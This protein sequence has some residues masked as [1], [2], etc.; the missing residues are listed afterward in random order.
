MDETDDIDVRDMVRSA[1]RETTS[2]FRETMR[3]SLNAALRGEQLVSLSAPASAPQRAR[4]LAVA[5][6]VLVVGVVAAVLAFADDD[7][8]TVTPVTVPPES[9][10]PTTAATSTEVSS[11]EVATTALPT[12]AVPTSLAVADPT[13]PLPDPDIPLLSV[14]A[15]FDTSTTNPPLATVR[16]AGDPL[17]GHSAFFQGDG[18]TVWEQDTDDGPL[19][20]T[21][22]TLDGRQAW[23]VDVPSLLGARHQVGTIELGP[24]DVLYAYY[25]GTEGSQVI[26][27]P[28]SGHRAGQT[29]ATWLVPNTCYETYCGPPMSADG[30][31]VSDTA[32]TP[33]VDGAG[34]P[35]GG[36]FQWPERAST[37]DD[38]GPAMPSAWPKGDEYGNS[39]IS[40]R[41]TVTLG[42][43]S[44]VFDAVGV[45]MAGD[46]NYLRQQVPGDG[47]VLVWFDTFDGVPGQETTSTKFLGI[48]SPDGAMA[49]VQL[50]ANVTDVHGS[51]GR[52][53][54]TTYDEPTGTYTLA[55]LVTG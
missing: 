17:F 52:I 51:D 36:T 24:F 32:T 41:T 15:R 28:T 7:R 30:L 33:Y 55:E 3:G 13:A 50:P 54:V 40:N 21:H 6:A 43:T 11:T 5:A 9:T 26:A 14:D 45:L 34:S 27:V 44:W 10:A 53:Y 49:F 25:E 2:E 29:V 19:R 12:T 31:I 46:Y 39:L 1:G 8:D 4:W 42:G 47:S 35:V 37:M 48:L 16:S 22:H 38:L 23:Q 20:I 18:W